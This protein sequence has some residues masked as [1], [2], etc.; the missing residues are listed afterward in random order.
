M[1]LDEILKGLE[2]SAAD[3]SDDDKSKDKDE[4]EDKGKDKDKDDSNPFSKK[5]KEEKEETQ[6]KK[7]SFKSGA[8]LAKEIMEKVASTKLENTKG[9]EMNKQASDAGKALAQALLTK[10]AGVGDVITENGI[11]DGVVPNKTQVDIAAQRAEHEASFQPTPGTDGA[12]N[13][14]TINQI[15]DSIVA[16]A[17]ARTGAI[18]SG[19]TPS[20]PAEGVINRQ[21]PNQEGVDDSQEKMAA[22]ISLVNSG[23]DFDEAVELVKAASFELEMEE[24]EHIKQ[25]TFNELI[26]NGV[27]FDLAAAMVKE[28]S[29]KGMATRAGRRATVLAGRGRQAVGRG[30]E[31]MKNFG[32]NTVDAAKNLPGRLS[33]SA[34]RGANSAGKF[35]NTIKGQANNALKA[36]RRHPY[37]TA[38]GVG[39]GVGAIGA[40]AYYA[41]REKQ[42]A[43]DELLDQG[44]DF[45]TAVEAIQSL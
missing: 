38:A 17:Q 20:T 36:A 18:V 14:G 40:G 7:A 37:A 43:L 2:K 10:L 45:D 27:D 1:T 28:A 12:G 9:E 5:P 11:P 13:G 39:A 35:G 23:L 30:I 29:L 31:A 19:Q 26:D 16:D 41:T 34:E 4:A 42:A 21:A 33:A 15:F 25:A 6:E 8:D 22:A 32:G 24:E 3:Q 44:F